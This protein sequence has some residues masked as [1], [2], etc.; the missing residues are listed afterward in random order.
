MILSEDMNLVWELE[1]HYLLNSRGKQI[2]KCWESLHAETAPGNGK[3]NQR[4]SYRLSDLDEIG[5]FQNDIPSYISIYVSYYHTKYSD[6]PS[7]LAAEDAW[8]I[9]Q[10]IQNKHFRKDC[11]FYAQFTVLIFFSK[12]LLFVM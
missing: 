7:T 1:M 5:F 4:F 8:T 3:N 9:Q 10:H 2:K 11:F 6:D 12:M